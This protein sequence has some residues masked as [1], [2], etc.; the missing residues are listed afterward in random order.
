VAEGK[1][2][3]AATLLN[4][5]SQPERFKYRV[6]VIAQRQNEA[7]GQLPAWDTSVHQGG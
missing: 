6:Q 4:S 3:S 1:P 2:G 5:G 7:R